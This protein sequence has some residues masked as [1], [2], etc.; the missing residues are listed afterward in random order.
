V[1]HGPWRNGGARALGV[2]GASAVQGR[3]PSARTAERHGGF[4][5]WEYLAEYGD[6]PV[7][8]AVSVAGGGRPARET[9]GRCLDSVPIWAFHGELD[10]VVDPQG[11]IEPT[12][13]LAA[14]RARRPTGPSSLPGGLYRREVGTPA[15]PGLD[16]SRPCPRPSS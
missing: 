13:N 14:V 12:T 15:R 3:R 11:T 2:P 9:A 10:D 4:G 7:A 16:L 8:A 6:E 1:L 5:T